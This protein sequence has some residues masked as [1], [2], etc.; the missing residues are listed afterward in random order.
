MSN[1]AP[2]LTSALAP[3]L[4]CH[5][6]SASDP[7]HAD[8]PRSACLRGLEEIAQGNDA[9]AA[10][11]TATRVLEDDERFN[12]GTGSNLRLDGS[13]IQMD[14]SCMRSSGEFGAVAA[15]EGVRNPIEVARLVLESP[16][17]LLAG[18]GATAFARRSGFAA[19]DPTTPG[20]RERLRAVTSVAGDL[21]EWT[22]AELEKAWNFNTPLR[23]A[24]GSDTVGCVAWDG[25]GFAG[26]LSSG[27]TTTVLRGRVGDVPLLGC[28]LYVGEHGAVAAT[29]DGE[30]IARALLAYRAYLELE[31]G[32][33]PAEVVTWA[34]DQLAP[35]VDVGLILVGHAGFAGGARHGMAWHGETLDTAS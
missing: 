29:G 32:R 5:A 2:V 15:I 18:E 4:V 9:L 17:I 23:E 7:A 30:D 19:F 6:G 16:H 25:T 28:G 12:A 3:V 20:A 13:T 35:R 21:G 31:R 22:R 8:G 14:A 24:L 1:P 33:A 27:G 26:A 10:A 34:L 11:V